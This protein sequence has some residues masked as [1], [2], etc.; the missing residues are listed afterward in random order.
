VGN[1]RR[2]TNDDGTKLKGNSD[3]G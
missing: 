3:E 2:A 1:G